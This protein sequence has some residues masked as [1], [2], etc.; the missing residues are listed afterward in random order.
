MSLRQI[1]NPTLVNWGGILV[2]SDS[3]RRDG[4]FVPDRS[5]RQHQGSAV[6]IETKIIHIRDYI[7]HVRADG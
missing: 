1:K 5:S 3:P 4:P 2:Y 6:I 7:S